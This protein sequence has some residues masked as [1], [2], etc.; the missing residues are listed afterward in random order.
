[1][2][3]VPAPADHLD[4]RAPRRAVLP[5]ERGDALPFGSASRTLR[6]APSSAPTALSFVPPTLVLFR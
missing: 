2:R 3:R 5:L 6:G 4:P 1:M